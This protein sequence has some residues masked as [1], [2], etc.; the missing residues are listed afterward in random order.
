MVG[1]GWLGQSQIS[2]LLSSQPAGW[3]TPQLALGCRPPFWGKGRMRVCARASRS[4]ISALKV[5]WRDFPVLAAL[6]NSRNAFLHKI[7][8]E[9]KA[10]E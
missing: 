1:G 2:W 5:G 8:Q 10:Q 3:V 9:Q 7:S 6:E 4:V